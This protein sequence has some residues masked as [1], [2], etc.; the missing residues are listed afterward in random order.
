[1]TIYH[2]NLKLKRYGVC[3]S[4]AME[5][6]L[7]EGN[8][9]SSEDAAARACVTQS[10]KKG[11]EV[12][13]QLRERLILIGETELADEL[14]FGSHWTTK[15]ENTLALLMLRCLDADAL[16]DEEEE[17]WEERLSLLRL[18]ASVS[19]LKTQSLSR[20]DLMQAYMKNLGSKWVLTQ[21]EVS[22]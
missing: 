11:F 21:G 9:Y 8:H 20:V 22:S 2:V 1:M 3:Y 4:S 10:P 6:P 17:T 14:D 15:R 18:I 16:P 7:G 5:C 19:M 12:F 13:P